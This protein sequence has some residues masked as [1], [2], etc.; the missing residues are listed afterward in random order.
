MIGTLN[1]I[2]GS[3]PFGKKL[4]K[5]IASCNHE[6]DSYTSLLEFWTTLLLQTA[7]GHSDLKDAFSQPLFWD[8]ST[9][10]LWDSDLDSLPVLGKVTF[11][12]YALQYCVTP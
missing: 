2:F 8:L 3:T 1:L 11:K 5:S 7:S 10:V 6:W 12:S 4:L 9:G